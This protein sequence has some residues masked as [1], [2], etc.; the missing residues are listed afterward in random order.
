M[1]YWQLLERH[2]WISWATTVSCFVQ[3]FSLLCLR[4]K[5][6]YSNL[7]LPYVVFCW[8]FACW[9]VDDDESDIE[10]S[11]SDED[12]DGHSTSESSGRRDDADSV[13][14]LI[15][16]QRNQSSRPTH[17]V[18]FFSLCTDHTLAR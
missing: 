3:K 12:D 6:W 4:D 1:Q 10:D 17:E 7:T 15:N 16:M 5:M 13:S 18:R 11:D 9:Y 8:E 2:M 14:N